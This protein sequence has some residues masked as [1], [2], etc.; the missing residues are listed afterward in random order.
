[1]IFAFIKKLFC[2]RKEISPD[3]LSYIG[4][5]THYFGKAKA[6]VIKLEAGEIRV[7]DEIYVKGHTTNF[8][9]KVA[10]MQVNG[11]AI[12]KAV[13]GNEI[14]ISVSKKTRSGDT[15]YKIKK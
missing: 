15:V 6:A 14:G 9:Q 3:K 13:K 5:I 4:K 8:T 2:F 11:K 7:D 12:E 1:M 10:S